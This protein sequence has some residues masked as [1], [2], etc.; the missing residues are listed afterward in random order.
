MSETLSGSARRT[1]NFSR[2][3]FEFTPYTLGQMQAKSGAA[4]SGAGNAGF[5][6]RVGLGSSANLSATVNYVIKRAGV[7]ALRLALPEGYRLE[8]VSGTNVLQW[9]DSKHPE[10]TSESV[11]HR[12]LPA[13][14]RSATE[15]RRRAKHALQPRMN[16]RI[17]PPFAPG[18]ALLIWF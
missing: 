6:L 15:A 3:H 8:S 1:A 4:A 13:D 14:G 2:I 9:T 5:D 12:R 10:H 11:L 17:A 18:G 7:F 16:A